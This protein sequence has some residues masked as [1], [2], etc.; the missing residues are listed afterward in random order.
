MKNLNVVPTYAVLFLL[1]SAKMFLIQ[2]FLG[3]QDIMHLSYRIHFLLF[4]ITLIGVL[5]MLAVFGLKKKNIIGFIFLGFVVFKLF[6]IGYI[7]LFEKDF[8]NN[9]LAYF[10][11]YWLYLAVEVAVVLALVRKQDEYHK[12]I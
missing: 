3:N 2:W 12:N 4:F 9:L 10:A 6:A 8:K 11:I 7:A 1:F 5:T